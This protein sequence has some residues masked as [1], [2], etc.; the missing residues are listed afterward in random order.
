MYGIDTASSNNDWLIIMC[1]CFSVGLPGGSLVFWQMSAFCCK[2]THMLKS[3]LLE[4]HTP[5]LDII[6]YKSHS[7]DNSKTVE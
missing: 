1:G 7:T 3:L 6:S 5:L 4:A 2:H